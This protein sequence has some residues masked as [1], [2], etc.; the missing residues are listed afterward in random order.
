MNATPSTR[1]SIVWNS[2]P[3]PHSSSHATISFCGRQQNPGGVVADTDPSAGRYPHSSSTAGRSSKVKDAAVFGE[4]AG[5]GR[6]L[7]ASSWAAVKM[8][9]RAPQAI[10]TTYST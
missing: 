1:Y 7:A 4:S 9:G 10:A 3:R 2:P 8:Q 5:F 6:W